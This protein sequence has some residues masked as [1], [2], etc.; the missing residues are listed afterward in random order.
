M[1]DYANK[2]FKLSD[3]VI[4][5]N[6]SI[7]EETKES[8]KMMSGDYNFDYNEQDKNAAGL[9]GDSVIMHVRG[10][11]LAQNY[12]VQKGLKLFGDQTAKYF[13]KELQQHHDIQK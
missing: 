13:T 8:L 12:S 9:V 11:I 2:T 3:G 1:I 7:L 4:H 10:V 6:P 5:I